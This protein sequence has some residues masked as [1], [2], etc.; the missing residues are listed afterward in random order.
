MLSYIISMWYFSL[1]IHFHRINH[2][3]TSKAL[4]I[5]TS[6]QAWVYIAAHRLDQYFVRMYRNAF[7]LVLLV[8]GGLI[9]QALF[10]PPER[11]ALIRQAWRVSRAQTLECP[12]EINAYSKQR[13]IYL[14][15]F[16]QLILFFVINTDPLIQLWNV[17]WKAIMSEQT[18]CTHICGCY[19]HITVFK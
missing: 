5:Q 12:G 11:R 16:R 9:S 19:L 15:P 6:F 14:R 3:Q 17:C 1:H 2:P 10:N 4:K 8:Y 13:R 18:K 7:V